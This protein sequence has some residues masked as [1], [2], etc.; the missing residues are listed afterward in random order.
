MRYMTVNTKKLGI[1]LK[2]YS[3]TKIN[4]TMKELCTIFHV[5]HST[6]GFWLKKFNIKTKGRIKSFI[7]K[8]GH[9]KRIT[10]KYKSGSCK[11]CVLKRGGKWKRKYPTKAR[12][13]YFKRVYG[14]SLAEFEIMF[15][16]QKGRCCICNISK[17]KI[18]KGK[19]FLMV[20]HN[21]KTGKIRG[22]LCHM[23]NLGLG[24]FGDNKKNLRKA[25]RYLT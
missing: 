13:A 22:L 11:A 7:C 9:D 2:K 24:Y 25:L 6:L 1:W 19:S 10:G 5:E 20:D 23:C 8:R 16:K 14:S 12:D 21:H 15:K 18:F 17:T 3:N 4:K